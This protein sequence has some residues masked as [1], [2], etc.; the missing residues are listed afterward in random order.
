MN[1]DWQEYHG[2]IVVGE[3]YADGFYVY[4]VGDSIADAVRDAKTK[5]WYRN[6][7]DE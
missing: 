3:Q 4:G 7:T 2:R 5:G 6:P 1:V